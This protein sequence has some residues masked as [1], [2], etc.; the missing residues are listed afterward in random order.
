MPANNLGS[1]TTRLENDTQQIHRL[2]G[3]M[4]GRQCQAFFTLFIGLLISFTSSWE[5]ALVTLS[6]FP[7]QAGANAIQMQVML[8]QGTDQEGVDGGAQASGLLTAAIQSIRTVSAFSMQDSLQAS[9]K[10]SIA[11]QSDSRKWRGI[12]S[13]TIFGLTQFTLFAT[14]GLLFWFGGGLVQ[15]GKYTF[16]EMMQAIM[17]ILMGAMG[18][19]QALTDMVDA[20]EARRDTDK[21]LD[22]MYSTKDLTI[23]SLS[24][25]G[26]T[27]SKCDGA[28]EFR[29]IHFR[30][31]ARQEQWVLGG[32]KNP[33]GYSL[34]IGAGQTVAFV[35]QSGS[36]KSTLIAFTLRFYDPDQGTVLLDGQDMKSIKVHS[37]RQHISYGK[38]RRE[39]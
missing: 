17:S 31:P 4:V 9:Y 7:I 6:T 1:L 33:E 20:K 30:Y 26:S 35:G 11:P 23:D 2:T 29:N 15:D 27:L 24:E 21:V 39:C 10:K 38:F 5:I 19:G 25:Q 36:G 8:G 13:G 18:L 34:T 32:P 22:L 12:V 14:Y 37:L 16:Q 28:I 3:D